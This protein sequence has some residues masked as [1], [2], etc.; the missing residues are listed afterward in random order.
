MQESLQQLQQLIDQ[1]NEADDPDE[2][3]DILGDII[4][5]DSPQ[6]NDFLRLV[7]AQEA[8][9]KYTRADAYVG[10]YSRTRGTE[11]TDKLLAY[12]QD[13]ESAYPYCVSAEALAE[14]G[15]PEAEPFLRQALD[16][17]LRTPALLATLSAL[18]RIAPQSTAEFFVERLLAL[19][20][21]AQLDYEQC[22]L[23][24]KSLATCG[25]K[26]FIPKL[27]EI[28]AHYFALAKKFPADQD[29]LEEFSE[30]ALESA[31]Q[32]GLDEKEA[33]DE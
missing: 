12:L 16:K 19:Q 17:S 25:L 4:R 10:L 28:G 11:G 18:E 30:Q 2:R 14:L 26:A 27:H 5:H 29:D 8:E 20:D 21:P 1:F 15:A 22:D 7:V 23:M 13:T 32:L 24:L 3:D 6:V 33:V 9:D 31:A